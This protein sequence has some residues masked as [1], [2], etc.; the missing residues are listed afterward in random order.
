MEARQYRI[1]VTLDPATHRLVGRTT[2]D[3]ECPLLDPLPAN[4]PCAVVLELHPELKV[5]DVRAAGATIARRY[6]RPGPPPP[7]PVGDDEETDELPEI[8]AVR[9]FIVLDRPVAAMTLAVDYEGVLFQDVQAGEKEGEIHN[10]AMEAH[11]GEDGIYLAGGP[12]YPTPV[13]EEDEPPSTAEYRLLVAPVE[14]F[15]LQAGAVRDPAAAELTGRLAW[16][17]PYPV[18]GMVLVGGRHEV[19]TGTHRGRHIAVHLKPEQ[20]AHAE[21]L[22]ATVQRIWDRYEP[23]LGPY[24]AQEYAIVDNFFSSG[25][26]FPAFTLLSSDAINMGKRAQM[27]HGMI[28]HEMLHCWWGNGVFVDPRDGNWCEALTSYCTNYYG[29]VLDGDEQ[30]ARRTRR[31]YC[32]FLSRMKAEKDKPLGTFGKPG[33]CGRGIAYSKGAMVFHMLAQKMG[34][35]DFWAALQRFHEQ[36]LGRHARWDDL[37]TVCEDVSRQ[38]LQAF[39][40][41][42]VRRGGAPMLLLSAAEYDPATRM[43]TVTVEQDDAEFA[44]DVPLRVTHAGGTLELLMPMEHAVQ[45]ATFALDVV[46]QAVEVDPDYHLFRKVPLRDIFPTTAGTR[47][48]KAFTTVLPGGDCPEAYRKIAESFASSFKDDER[49][50][51]TAGAVR[52]EELV[53]R[54]AVVLGEA[55]RDPVVSAFLTGIEFPVQ[56]TDEGFVFEGNTYADAAEAVMCTVSHPAVEGGGI[57]VVYANSDEAIPRAALLPM[58]DSSLVIFKNGMA[59]H[60][61][62]FERRHAVPVKGA[63]DGTKQ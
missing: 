62:D 24:P 21:G 7:R 52:S 37:R 12:W 33:G 31:N 3:L 18:D 1:E 44:L 13:R 20:A 2:M 63:G 14:G 54:C 51:R 32:H 42:W 19:H 57:T 39:F 46:P 56:W 4:R 36:Y 30:N 29:Y 40:E 15:E 26:A 8:V 22:L 5:T 34:Q 61:A 38:D 35:E 50:E 60:R 43:L 27:R 53:Q 47:F 55:V 10:F 6:S 17:S 48:G 11:I 23:L 49:I 58:Y 9:H 25:F 16:R 45:Q 59:V 28:D 41:Q